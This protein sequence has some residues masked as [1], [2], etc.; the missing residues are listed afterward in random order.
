M[1]DEP[2]TQEA[3]QPTEGQEGYQGSDLYRSVLEK[4]PED[5]RPQVEGTLKEWDRGVTKRFQEAAE[6]RKQLEQ[7]Q[8]LG[9]TDMDREDL[10][11]AVGLVKLAAEDPDAFDEWLLSV[12]VERGLID[13]DALVDQQQLV[14]PDTENGVAGDGVDIEERVQQLLEEKLSPFQ[15]YLAQQEYERSVAEAERLIDEKLAELRERHG[16][17]DEEAI[18]VIANGILAQNPQAGPQAIEDAFNMFSK[19]SA[20]GQQKLL[21][22]SQN[23]PAPAE[24]GGAPNVGAQPIRSFRDAREQALAALRGAVG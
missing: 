16:D 17:F 8:E 5:L 22:Q 10:E 3:Q 24:R 19:L 23:Q 20:Q 11:A 9:V 13:P 15:E 2:I 4:I 6:L 18:L 12:A 14:E 7:F 1:T 21:E